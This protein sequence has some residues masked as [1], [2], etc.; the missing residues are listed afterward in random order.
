[1]GRI[2]YF[3][4][5]IAEMGEMLLFVTPLTLVPILVAVIF[6]EWDMLIPLA[7][8]PALFFGIGTLL[9]RL[10]R[11]SRDVRLSMALCSVALVWFA[12]ASISSLP[13]ILV[14]DLSV[15]SAL[16]ET[17]AGWTGTG[18]TLLTSV[19]TIPES[20]IFWRVYMQWVGGLGII[21]LTLNMAQRAGLDRSPLF[22]AESRSDRILPGAVSAGK[23]V[24][25]AYVL[26]TI[27]SVGLILMA[28]LPLWDAINLA[29]T[30][31]STGGFTPHP[32]GILS[33]GNP[34]LEALLIP[35]MILGSIPFALF[36]MTYKKRS[37]SLF[38]DYQVRLL[39]I[40]LIFGSLIVAGDLFFFSKVSPFEAVRQGVFMTAA[41]I[42]TTGFQNGNPSLYPVVTTIFLT[43]LIFVGGSSGSTAG[44]VKLS[45]IAMG[46]R[47][48]VWWFNRVFVRSKVLVP[49]R[50]E[51]RTVPENV[52]EPEL[53]KDMFVIILSVLTV[54][55]AL[56]IIL[57]VHILSIT[58]TDLIFDIVSA[59]SSSGM[60]A[61]YVNP[62]MPLISKWVFIVV[63]WIG[64]L[65]VIPVMVLFMG[66]LRGHD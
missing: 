58:V 9:S 43:M 18:F 65:E 63:M 12:F 31:I 14:M 64:R 16:F 60:T 38:S 2:G 57:Q 36:Y 52:A 56:M 48:L 49:F 66:L 40:T 10:P 30:T 17:M 54:F 24:L 33:Y 42:S 22:H 3:A 37:V 6:M 55:I 53:A 62:S 7:T 15:T 45:R 25:G 19:E 13:F 23:Q 5:V 61:G 27:I 51:G 46:Y 28:R 32:G 50:Y 8:V 35:V 59:L 47:G 44:G 34:L 39:L 20:L 11:R 26:L 4:T 21:A 1:M 29:L 41:A